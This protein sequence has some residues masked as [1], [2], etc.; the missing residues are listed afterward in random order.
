MV[1]VDED[2]G[3]GRIIPRMVGIPPKIPALTS[4]VTG[5]RPPATRGFSL[6][7]RMEAYGM[8]YLIR[9]ISD[10]GKRGEGRGG[11]GCKQANYIGLSRQVTSGFPFLGS[12]IRLMKKY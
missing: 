4:V 3:L 5:S 10:V 7:S 12:L 9:T 6:T 11:E 2:F 1:E 8:R